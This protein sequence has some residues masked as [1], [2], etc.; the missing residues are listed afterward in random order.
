[1]QAIAHLHEWCI[2]LPSAA[3][4]PARLQEPALA[5]AEGSAAQGL[6]V[7]AAGLAVLTALF[8]YDRQAGEARIEQCKAGRWAGGRWAARCPACSLDCIRPS[9]W[10][11]WVNGWGLEGPGR[12]GALA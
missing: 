3:P 8:L 11:R 1:M 7:D 9:P 5:A 2:S 6:A 12:L 10:R 4:A